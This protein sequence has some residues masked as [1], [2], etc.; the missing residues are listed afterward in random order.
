MFGLTWLPFGLAFRE[1]RIGQLYVKCAYVGVD[2]D[3]VTVA[4][5]PDRPADGRFRPYMADAE[6][7]G[8]AGKPAIGDQGDLAAH[9]LTGQRP[10]GREHFAHPGAATRPLIAD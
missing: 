8:C 7:A 9:A 6:P 2:F 5:Q 10:R 4:Q 3:D 1:L